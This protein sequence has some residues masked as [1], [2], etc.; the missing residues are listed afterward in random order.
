MKAIRVMLI[1]SVLAALAAIATPTGA[2][3]SYSSCFQLAN[4]ES[5]EATVAITFYNQDGSVAG[6]ITSGPLSKIA[7]NQANTYCPLDAVSSG[8]N[9]SVVVSS[10]KRIASIA[11]VS[12]DSDTFWGSYSGL[13]SVAQTVALP[14]IMKGNYGFNTWFNVQNAGSG[15]TNVTVTYSNG[16]TE[17]FNGLKPG[18]AHTFNQATNAGLGTKFVGS[19]VVSA[20]TGGQIAVAVMEVGPTTLLAYEGFPKAA[21]FPVMPL[22]NANNYK[23]ATGI[24]IQNTSG[25]PSD[26]T[27]SYT[28][29][30]GYPGTACTEKRTIPAGQSKTFSLYVFTYDESPADPT[31]VTNCLKSTTH[32]ENDQSRAFVGSGR[33]TI[34]T[35]NVDLTVI[36]NQVNAVGKKG[37]SYNGFNPDDATNSLAFP[38]IM[39]RNYQYWTG[40]SVVNVG[41]S[42]T[43]INCTFSNSSRTASLSNVVPGGVLVD[44]QNG[45]IA[46]K[47]VGLATCTASGGTQNKIVGVVNEVKD[48][49][50][51]DSFMTYEGAN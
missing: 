19:A 50:N 16:T 5:T 20:S 34:N 28:P 3:S 4:M 39:D 43:N 35:A 13:A 2:I 25:S 33:V 32:N 26:V 27:V 46:D 44:I 38:L 24:Q 17:T 37:A 22:V 47:Y 9:G 23:N 40:F 49:V 15:D 7:G 30:A 42:N 11:N 18:A 29:G 31:L 45:A 1:V 8:F 36:V 12:G 41:S 10:D 21:K 51:Y 14:L 48:G 6:S